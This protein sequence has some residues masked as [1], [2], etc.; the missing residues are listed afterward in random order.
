MS[1]HGDCWGIGSTIYGW[2][3]AKCTASLAPL[4]C[5]GL[6]LCTFGFHCNHLEPPPPPHVAFGIPLSELCSQ[7]PGGVPNLVAKVTQF[8]EDC[9]EPLWS[10]ALKWQSAV[11]MRAY[12]SYCLL[13]SA[14][15]CWYACRF[16]HGGSVSV[17]S[18]CSNH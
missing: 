13:H 1:L 8:V 10:C 12:A 18:K 17:E 7:S 9:C 15:C 5:D 16:G 4:S 3:I 2:H 6:N 14:M 11:R